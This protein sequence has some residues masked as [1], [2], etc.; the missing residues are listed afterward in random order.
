MPDKVVRFSSASSGVFFFGL[1]PDPRSLLPF[2]RT[3]YIARREAAGLAKGVEAD[4]AASPAPPA[5]GPKEPASKEDWRW[6]ASDGSRLIHTQVPFNGSFL[7]N[8][9]ATTDECKGTEQCR[10]A[11]RQ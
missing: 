2:L 1:T 5:Q 4:Q 6:H 7:C 10:G 3:D 11:Q 8:V 9:M